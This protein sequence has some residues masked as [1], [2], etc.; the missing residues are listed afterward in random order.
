MILLILG[1]D[2]ACFLW[3]HSSGIRAISESVSSI[4]VYVI[5]QAGGTLDSAVTGT[6]KS[7]VR[8]LSAL[9]ISVDTKQE[10]S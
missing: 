3:G 1:I 7:C 5:I 2:L 8:C 9:P 4:V 6:L 10:P